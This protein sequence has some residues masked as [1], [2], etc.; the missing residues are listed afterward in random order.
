M[1]VRAKFIANP[2]MFI[3]APSGNIKEVLDSEMPSRSR[4]TYIVVASV[5]L[6]LEVEK[7]S[8]WYSKLFL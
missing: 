4:Q 2:S 8:T 5:A 1:V 3:D 7:A 6:L